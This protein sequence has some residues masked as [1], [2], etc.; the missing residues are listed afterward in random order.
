MEKTASEMT[1]R[2]LR[3]SKGFTQ[4]QTAEAIGTSRGRLA[5]LE[6]RGVQR[7]VACVQALGGT[8]ELSVTFPGEKR[9]VLKPR[10]DE[11]SAAE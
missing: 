6:R 5:R 1:L 4:K 9:I 10:P 8:L 3:K 2:E 11:D 7:L